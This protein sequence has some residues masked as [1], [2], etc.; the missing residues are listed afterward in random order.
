MTVHAILLPAIVFIAL[1]AIQ[2]AAIITIL[3]YSSRYRGQVCPIHAIS[4]AHRGP[5]DR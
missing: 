4:P 1:G 2:I 3:I 5:A